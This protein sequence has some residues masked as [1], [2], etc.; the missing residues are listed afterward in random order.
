MNTVDM[1]IR[2]T[3]QF[4][5]Q[6]GSDVGFLVFDH[7]DE[8]AYN[9]KGEI[10]LADVP[11]SLDEITGALTGPFK[12]LD[13]FRARPF[14]VFQAGV[15]HD[16]DAYVNA[17]KQLYR[18]HYDAEHPEWVKEVKKKLSEGVP[19]NQL[20]KAP[21]PP[22]ELVDKISKIYQ[23]FANEWIGER[24]F[25]VPHLSDCVVDYKLFARGFYELNK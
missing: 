2:K 11:L 9:D 8:Y 6:R 1:Y 12:D 14:K 24:K 4:A 15:V 13:E 5:Q 22:E 25:D 16:R 3:T 21:Q 7:K 10:I 17:S 19:K 18:D 20:P 23:A